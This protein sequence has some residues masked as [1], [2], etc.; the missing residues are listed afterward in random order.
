VLDKT[1]RII[2]VLQRVLLYSYKDC[3]ENNCKTGIRLDILLKV[4]YCLRSAFFNSPNVSFILLTIA[5]IY[6]I[7]KELCAMFCSF[8]LRWLCSFKNRENILVQLIFFWFNNVN[9]WFCIARIPVAFFLFDFLLENIA[10]ESVFKHKK[11]D[12]IS[13][14]VYVLFRVSSISNSFFHPAWFPV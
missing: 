11:V 3:L 1:T 7:L 14:W 5:I 8:G 13:F 12:T 4:W 10:Y 6:C 9:A 2:V